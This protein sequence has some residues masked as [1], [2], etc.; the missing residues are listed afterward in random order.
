[1]VCAVVDHIDGPPLHRLGGIVDEAAERA[2]VVGVEREVDTAEVEVVHLAERRASG[3]DH[4]VVGAH[5]G[6]PTGKDAVADVGTGGGVLALGEEGDGRVAVAHRLDVAVM[7]GQPGCHPA[8]EVRHHGAFTAA[9]FVDVALQGALA[10]PAVGVGR[11]EGVQKV[12]VEADADGVVV[13]LV[14]VY[15]LLQQSKLFLL[16][17]GIAYHSPCH[18]VE[19]R[20]RKV[21]TLALPRLA[22]GFQ[23]GGRGLL[24]QRLVHQRR[25]RHA[26]E[27]IAHRTLQRLQ[28]GQDGAVARF[29]AV[30]GIIL[31]HAGGLA[32]I[33]GRRQ[34]VGTVPGGL[35]HLLGLGIGRL[36]GTVANQ[37]P[38][39]LP[40][41]LRAD[42]QGRQ[43]RK[44]YDKSF[45]CFNCLFFC[46]RDAGAPY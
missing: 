12:H 4:N 38:D 28:T 1:M 42:G 44:G 34:Q 33:V 36:V 22:E 37:F 40:V 9:I 24:E 18:H 41:G 16:V 23:T 39:V 25:I 19:R 26:E 6:Q 2:A 17:A 21:D 27:S 20:G 29:G 30:E 3:I 7:I 45:H 10:A 32:H 35:E 43:Q 8:V 15:E 13:A 31:V 14:E 5:E 46:R 11:F